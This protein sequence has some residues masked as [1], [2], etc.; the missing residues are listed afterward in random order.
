MPRIV[1]TARRYAVSSSSMARGEPGDQLLAVPELDPHLDRPG[2]AA[3]R[4]HVPA[5]HAHLDPLERQ[6]LAQALGRL[7]GQL[8]E[9]GARE[10]PL[11][12]RRHRPQPHLGGA[13][14]G[15]VAPDRE[16]HGP[17]GGLDDPPAHL[18]DE[19]RAVAA[20]AVDLG[21]EAQRVLE[22]EVELHVAVVAV[23]HALGPQRAHGPADEVVALVAEQLGGEP[24]DED[25]AA[26][27][28]GGDG[29]VRQPLEH[30]EHGFER[31]ELEALGRATYVVLVFHL[32][33]A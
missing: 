5:R 1:P 14:L 19:L 18:A 25:D 28:A 31:L 6:R 12:Q 32:G 4:E 22:R 9:L 24:V 16:Q 20:Q 15:D 10:R 27:A 17:G 33:A 29:G 8:L 13:P 30:R 3:G 2:R 26:V 21:R 23:A 7:A 11:A